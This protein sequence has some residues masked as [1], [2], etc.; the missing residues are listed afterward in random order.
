MEYKEACNCYKSLLYSG[1][2]ERKNPWRVSL[3]KALLFSQSTEHV[4]KDLTPKWTNRPSVPPKPSRLGIMSCEPSFCRP[5]TNESSS[6]REQR[7][8]Q[9][10]CLVM[11]HQ[12]LFPRPPTSRMGS[13]TG[14]QQVYETEWWG[15]LPQLWFA[16]FPQQLNSLLSSSGG[17]HS[18]ILF[19]IS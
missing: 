6:I 10:L 12:V 8:A 2:P 5:T 18:Q 17:I 19:W 9:L 14:N 15:R 16:L 7:K 1:K 11:A 13:L 3:R 4:L